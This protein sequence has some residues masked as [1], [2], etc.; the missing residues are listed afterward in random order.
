M[1]KYVL[2]SGGIGNNLP[3]KREFHREL[4]KGLGKAPRF[5]LCNFAQGREY[6]EPKFVAY[7]QSI[8]EDMPRGVKPTFQLAMP[9]VMAEQCAAA[10]VIYF[11]GGDCHL[12]FYWMQ[13]FDLSKLF[14]GKV[15][16]TNSASS[17]MLASSFWT[18]DWRECMDGLGVL[19]CKV[20]P[21]YG[22]AFGAEDPRGLIDW[23]AAHSALAA[24]GDPS[25]PIYALPE[26]DFVVIETT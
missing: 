22:S 7:A 17:C 3:R 15:V 24:Y 6:W 23:Q 9:N 12:L 8:L 1:T 13:Q 11:H 18:C 5:V 10:D 20:I 25:L 2:N 14:G 19:P 4:V 21:H 16:A 26:G